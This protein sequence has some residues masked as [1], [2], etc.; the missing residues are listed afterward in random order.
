MGLYMMH[1]WK[2]VQADWS[3]PELVDL[4]KGLA[5]R[6]ETVYQSVVTPINIWGVFVHPNYGGRSG[7]A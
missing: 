2:R 4:R 5:V 6:T 7:E 1:G 3:A